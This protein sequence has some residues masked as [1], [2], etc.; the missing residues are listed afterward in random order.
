M[1]CPMRSAQLF[2]PDADLCRAV[3]WARCRAL[4]GL[5]RSK[6]PWRLPAS[7]CPLLLLLLAVAAA[8]RGILAG[9]GR[10]ALGLHTAAARRRLRIR[11]DLAL[12]IANATMFEDTRNPA[13]PGAAPRVQV[14]DRE[15]LACGVLNVRLGVTWHG[16]T[17]IGDGRDGQSGGERRG[18]R[19][20]GSQVAV[21]EMWAAFF[22]RG[23]AARMGWEETRHGCFHALTKRCQLC[24]RRASYGANGGQV[25]A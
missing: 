17:L 21:Q 6:Q 7:R 1:V 15:C 19:G 12:Q 18:Q 9:H 13:G 11:S 10:N 8:G 3:V 4:L 22:C 2:W 20:G 23:C 16:I 14:P 24:V 5:G 25:R